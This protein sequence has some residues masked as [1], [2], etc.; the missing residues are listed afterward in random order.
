LT[1]VNLVTTTWCALLPRPISKLT[2]F[3]LED[4][5]QKIP[6]RKM[7]ATKSGWTAIVIVKGVD[8]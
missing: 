7:L 8:G 3:W 1:A 5:R 6:K 2:H 4:S